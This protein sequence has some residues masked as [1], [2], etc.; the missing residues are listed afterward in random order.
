[1]FGMQGEDLFNGLGFE[2]LLNQMRAACEI[3]M[4]TLSLMSALTIPDICG[5]IDS[6]NGEASRSSYVN[7]FDNHLPVYGSTFDG[8]ECYYLRCKLLHQGITTHDKSKYERI[9]FHSNRDNNGC[10]YHRCTMKVAQTGAT[11]LMLSFEDFVSDI[12]EAAIKWYQKHPNKRRI[13]ET[14][15]AMLGYSNYIRGMIVYS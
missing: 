10:M 9:T 1:M 8:K 15:G 4:F 5:G 11:V 7:W 2:T 12:I 14:F 3:K 6:A 13:D